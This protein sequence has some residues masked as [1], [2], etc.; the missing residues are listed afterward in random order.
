MLKIKML[1]F[2]ALAFTVT[3]IYSGALD[4][5]SPLCLLV[6]WSVK[7]RPIIGNDCIAGFTPTLTTGPKKSNVS[8]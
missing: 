6:H 3:P 7:V 2:A 8:S 4:W 5:A 1:A